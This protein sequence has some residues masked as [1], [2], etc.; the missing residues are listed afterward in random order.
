MRNLSTVLTAFFCLIS[1][2][3]V[4]AAQEYGMASVYSEKFQG[5]RTASGEV[6]T[7][8]KMT[9][10]HRNLPFGTRVKVTRTDN[11]KSVIVRINDRGP[12]V[13]ERVTDLSKSA[14][15][16]LGI[17]DDSDEIRVKLEVYNE[18]TGEVTPIRKPVTSPNIE[19]VPMPEP[20]EYIAGKG[21][22]EHVVPREY[23]SIQKNTNTTPTVNSK[24]V[25]QPINKAPIV[26][27]PRIL[28]TTKEK[29]NLYK[30]GTEAV[31]AKNGFAVQVASMINHSSMTKKVDE[32]HN[33]HYNNILV[34]I[35]EGKDGNPDYKILLGPFANQSQA[36]S[37][38]RSLHKKNTDGFVVNLKNF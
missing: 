7:H 4:S 9:A 28:S 38:L 12:F 27:S 21:I 22:Q 3:A 6:F 2:A 1:M 24:S 32:L 34:N 13:S 25:A 36:V 16:K 33:K 15:Q 23:R 5:S 11:G 26:S 18:K 19:K 35:V 14:A 37:Y 30:V 10:A 17:N 29:K 31:S 20:A 8:S